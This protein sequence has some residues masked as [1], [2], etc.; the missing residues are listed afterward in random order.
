MRNAECGM[1]KWG[2]GGTEWGVFGMFGLL[3]RS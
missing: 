2:M 1:R 3:F